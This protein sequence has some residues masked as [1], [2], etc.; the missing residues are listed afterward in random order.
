MPLCR[1][2]C[3]FTGEF[4]SH[5]LLRGSDFPRRHRLFGYSVL[6]G[7]VEPAVDNAAKWRQEF[8]SCLPSGYAG[9]YAEISICPC[10]TR[11]L[12]VTPGYCVGW[13]LL[14]LAS[15]RCVAWREFIISIRS[16]A[17]PH[18]FTNSNWSN[19]LLFV[20]SFVY[21]QVSFVRT[22]FRKDRIPQGAIGCLVTLRWMVL[23]S[24]PW[25]I[26]LNGD[27]N[28]CHACLRAT[29]Q[30]MPKFQYDHAAPAFGLRRRLCPNF[31]FNCCRRRSQH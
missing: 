18:Y 3:I 9:G 27:K 30:A 24:L 23:V 11:L 8:V 7:F 5:L 4:V 29:L 31:T 26:L 20:D 14:Y 21:S 12:R 13:S 10:R 19:C 6:D 15:R 17:S 16:V 28:L 22:C 25:T 2:V 1:F